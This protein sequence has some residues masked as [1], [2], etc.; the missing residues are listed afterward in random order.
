MLIFPYEKFL[1]K[2]NINIQVCM[3]IICIQRVLTSCLGKIFYSFDF[4]YFFFCRYP[5]NGVD[6]DSHVISVK[7][8]LY[9]T[10]TYSKQINFLKGLTK[11][12]TLKYLHGGK[13]MN[14]KLLY[15]W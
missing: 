6:T 1:C 13:K 9:I 3:V 4:F 12:N 15:N 2:K 8:T 5:K 14:Q 10:R 7:K 11:N